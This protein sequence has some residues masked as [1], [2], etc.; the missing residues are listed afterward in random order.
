[1]T[2]MN[3][4][5][6]MLAEKN[7]PKECYEEA[8]NWFV[9]VQNRSP[10][11]I[12]KDKTPEEVWSGRKPSIHF[13]RVFGCIGHVHVPKALRKKLDNRSIKCVLLGVS[14]ESKVYR[15]VDPLSKKIYIG[16][17]VVFS[18]DGK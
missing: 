5:R 11:L 17:D 13:F 4:V 3:M 7:L 18:E 12:V 15:L 16:R 14:E 8:V 1:M 2:I 6:C 9:F 10:T